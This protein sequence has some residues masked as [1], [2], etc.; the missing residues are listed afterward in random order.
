MTTRSKHKF[1]SLGTK[2]DKELLLDKERVAKKP[3]IESN[4]ITGLKIR[5]RI[6]PTLL[7]HVDFAKAEL[8]TP[9][10][11]S[12]DDLN[13]LCLSLIVMPQAG[14]SSDDFTAELDAIED[15][16]SESGNDEQDNEFDAWSDLDTLRMVL[17]M[18]QPDAL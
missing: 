3:K 5:T 16:E 13:F 15:T 10:V 14:Y 17:T 2:E 7:L 18:P 1:P 6:C 11:N 12:K 8:N 4:R 9:H